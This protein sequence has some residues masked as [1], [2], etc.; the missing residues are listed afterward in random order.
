[1]NQRPAAKL[2]LAADAR[3]SQKEGSQP[4]TICNAC[5]ISI[6]LVTGCIV[7]HRLETPIKYQSRGYPKN[8]V[9]IVSKPVPAEST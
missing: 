2:T 3:L 8:Y 6:R 7:L 4:C 9:A 1:M 5:L